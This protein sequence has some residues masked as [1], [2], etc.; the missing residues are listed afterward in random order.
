[1][2]V[3]LAL[4]HINDLPYFFIMTSEMFGALLYALSADESFGFSHTHTHTELANDYSDR[5]SGSGF[6]QTHDE[7]DHPLF[8]KILE[9]AHDFSTLLQLQ[10]VR[11]C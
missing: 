7:D 4:L 6:S 9:S 11:P 8:S 2:I 5:F 1:M 10:E 3:T